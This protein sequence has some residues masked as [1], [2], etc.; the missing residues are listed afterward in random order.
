MHVVQAYGQNTVP[1]WVTEGI[2][3]YVRST[4]GINNE[5]AKWSLPDV[6]PEHN[7]NNSYR[8]TARFFIWIT[9]RYKPNFVQMLDDAARKNEYSE[10]TFKNITGKNVEELW[11]EY[12]AD[13]TIK[14]N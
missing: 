14:L 13:S 2:A 5:K 7:Y 12:V 1:G 3:D 8:I 9:E 4:E 11:K 6:K 10:A